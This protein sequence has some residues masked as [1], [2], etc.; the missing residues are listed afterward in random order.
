MER[1]AGRRVDGI[2]AGFKGIFITGLLVSIPVVLTVFALWWFFTLVDGLLGPAFAGLLG[3]RIPGVGFLSSLLIIFLIGLVATNVVGRRIFSWAERLFLHI[4]IAKTVYAALK[5]MMDALNPE[6][7][8]SFRRFV[9]VEYPR[10]GTY[11]FGFLTDQS[12]LETA[13]GEE[14][15]LVAVYVPTNHLYLGETVLLPR[16]DVI[17][18]DLTVEEGVRIVLSGGS[19]LPARIRLKDYVRTPA[20]R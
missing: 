1:A 5:S 20:A 16:R 17:F 9:I 2:R 18:P 15:H 10:P 19:I 3:Y 13:P 11:A 6:R 4:P 14:A 8:G 7:G 12:T